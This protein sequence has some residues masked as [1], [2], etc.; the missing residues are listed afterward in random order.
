[1][2]KMDRYELLRV[3]EKNLKKM[4]TIEGRLENDLKKD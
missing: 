3:I 1:M 2:D 4:D